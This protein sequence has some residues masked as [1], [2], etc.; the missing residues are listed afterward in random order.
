MR[1]LYNTAILAI[2]LALIA[3]TAW[4]AYTS[5]IVFAA[6]TAAL[7]VVRGATLEWAR[8]NHELPFYVEG[9]RSRSA[10]VSVA[11]VALAGLD[12]LLKAVFAAAVALLTFSGTDQTRLMVASILLALVAFFATSMLRRLSLSFRVDPARWGYFRLAVPLGVLYSLGMQ[13]AVGLGLVEP[14]SLSEIGRTI[15]FELPE[16]PGLNDVAELLFNV[17]QAL[18]T[19]VFAAL[20]RF[21]EPG[22][23]AAVAVLVSINILSGMVIAIYA[24][25]IA[26]IVRRLEARAA[27]A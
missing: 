23:A 14:Q 12:A 20:R 1:V 18:D 17:R 5:P 19:I 24:V 4:L 16:R 8:L 9:R 3:A 25:L 22:Y 26:D 2:E 13:A 11:I 21:L 15:V 10:L 7:V 27:L 6:V